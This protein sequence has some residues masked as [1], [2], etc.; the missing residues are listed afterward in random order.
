MQ[1]PEYKLDEYTR[2]LQIQNAGGVCEHCG[3]SL[4]HFRTCVL[5][6][7]KPSDWGFYRPERFTHSPLPNP[8]DEVAGDVDFLRKMG[9]GG[10]DNR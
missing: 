7:L 3:S 6:T 2:Q 10:E 5:L 4:G 8:Q 9:I 1:T